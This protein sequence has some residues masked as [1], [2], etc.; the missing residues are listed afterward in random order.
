M[1]ENLSADKIVSLIIKKSISVEEVVDYYL[2]R[3]EKLNPTVNAIV[4]LKNEKKIRAEAKE[5]DLIKDNKS[6]LLYGL[7]LAV[8]DLFDVENIPTTYGL[9]Q[10]KDNF[11]AKN[12]L[13]VD[14]L[15]DHGAIIIGKTN[16]PEF[17]V[18]AHT[19][20]KLFGPTVNPYNIN[21]TAGGSSGGSAAAI[22]SGLVPLSDGTDMMGSCRIPAAY[23]N[24]Y[25][26]RPTPGLIPVERDTHQSQNL[27]NLS[28]PGCLS[29]TP[30]EISLML[31]AI[32]GKHPKDP[33]SFDLNSSFISSTLN[34]N[35]FEKIKIGWLRDMKGQYLFDHEILEL[36]ETALNKLEK[37]KV[38]IDLANIDMKSN[39][40]WN[41]WTTLRSKNLFQ[42]IVDM[43]L[44]NI[45][46]LHPGIIWEYNKGQN[47]TEL[48]IEHAIEQRDICMNKIDQLF[49]KF[50]FLALPSAQI[51]PFDKETDYPKR[52]GSTELDTYHR[53]MEVTIL[54]SL[55][56]LPT[57]S[58]PI[59]FNKE[60]MPMGMQ[61]I[62]RRR[63]DLDLIAFAKI[64]EE[65]FLF[66]KHR[67][68]DFN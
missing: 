44:N 53:W 17:A 38:Q 29:R 43:E 52:I 66:S 13:I 6:K 28:T 39:E 34:Q 54:A 2:H 8:K 57:I 15:L 35:Q 32:S 47:I 58:I 3:I 16:I 9:R 12:S 36:C 40:I 67:P 42:D 25:G 55:L 37:H 11:P 33:L 21:T 1:L 27:P 45:D 68:A 14:R 18:G 50:N 7:P 51:F 65:I 4:S 5:K 31:D 62:A 19:S 64:Y 41:S 26:M 61:I 30:H 60:G 56:S 24:I 20:N 48:N 10:F 46:D 22:A 23:T 59:G 49:H 63:K